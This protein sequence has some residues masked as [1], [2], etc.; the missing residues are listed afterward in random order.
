LN[1]GDS[2]AFVAGESGH[3]GVFERAFQISNQRLFFVSAQCHYN[4]SFGF[5][6]V[7]KT[8]S[9]LY[10]RASPLSRGGFFVS[11]KKSSGGS[12]LRADSVNIEPDSVLET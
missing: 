10:S 6:V 3:F 7:S 4:F 1:V 8:E 2:Q 5:N 11:G 9:V 12:R